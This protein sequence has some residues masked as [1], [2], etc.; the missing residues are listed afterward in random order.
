MLRLTPSRE[1]T[2]FCIDPQRFKVRFTH[3]SECH[4]NTITFLGKCMMEV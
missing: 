1:P 2:L 4:I 3:S